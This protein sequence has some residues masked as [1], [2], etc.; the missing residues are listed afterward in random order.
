MCSFNKKLLDEGMGSFG[1]HGQ[2]S[3]ALQLSAAYTLS[4]WFLLIVWLVFKSK[5]KK[6]GTLMCV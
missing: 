3:I 2:I 1:D 5:K 6:Q 4:S